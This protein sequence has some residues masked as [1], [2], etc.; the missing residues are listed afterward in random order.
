[1]GTAQGLSLSCSFLV[2]PPECSLMAVLW[3]KPHLLFCLL[4][5]LKWR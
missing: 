1:M 5:S 4:P 2:P 3:L